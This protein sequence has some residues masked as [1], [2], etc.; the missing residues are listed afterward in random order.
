MFKQ[1]VVSVIYGFPYKLM[2]IAI[3]AGLFHSQII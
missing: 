1:K 2:E 3:P